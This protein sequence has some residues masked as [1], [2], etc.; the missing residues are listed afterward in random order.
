[1]PVH[2]L[3]RS[4]VVH[5][6]AVRVPSE[7]GRKNIG[8]VFL[9]DRGTHLRQNLVKVGIVDDTHVLLAESIAVIA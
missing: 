1:M 9:G 5:G 8:E 3:E 2:R 7:D 4:R 6:G